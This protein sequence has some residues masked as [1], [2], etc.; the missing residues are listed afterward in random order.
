[1][2]GGA[3]LLAVLPGSSGAPAAA[4]TACALNR[5]DVGIARRGLAKWTLA[6]RLPG[7]G[8][9]TQETA[10]DGWQTGLKKEHRR[11]GML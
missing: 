6:A 7:C 11:A 10:D 4:Q 3:S 5:V 8:P 9:K 1:M 2:V